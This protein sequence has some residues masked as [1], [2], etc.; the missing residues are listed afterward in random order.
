MRNRLEEG[1][2]LI[3]VQGADNVVVRANQIMRPLRPENIQG[4]VAP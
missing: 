1:K 2:Y 4:Y 3:I